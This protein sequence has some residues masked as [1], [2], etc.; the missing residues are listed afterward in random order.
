MRRKDDLV[1]GL[2]VGTTKVCA[3]VAEK[4]DNGDVRII[5]MGM[6]PSNGLRKG[7]VVNMESTIGSIGRAIEKAE[8]M[9]DV[10]INSVFAGIAG[11]HID[12]FNSRACIPIT[13]SSGEILESDIQKALSAARAT[14][15]PIDREVVH[16][17]PQGFLVD[18]HEVGK[19]PRGMSGMRL[20]AKVHIITGAIT[21]AQ[22]IILCI[23]RAGFAVED[24]VLEPLASALAVLTEE[25]K[26]SGVL[27][28]DIGG[29]TTDYVV[30]TGGAIR[31]SN[32]L[33]L[34]GDHLTND[35]A[36]VLKIPMS[37]AEEIKKEYASAGRENVGESDEIAVRC[38]VGQPNRII[39]RK[40]LCDIAH[41]RMDEIFSLIMREIH[42]SGYERRIS[43]G[44][45]LTGGASLLPGSVRMA[46]DIFDMPVR[47]GSPMG[48]SGLVEVLDNPIFATGVGLSKFGSH[49]R[50]SA[51]ESRFKGRHLF[52]RVLERMSDWFG[53][54]L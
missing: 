37:K 39:S 18:G 46:A 51:M 22:N 13:R 15:I 12:S 9:S 52:S 4:G 21:S 11:G 27:L 3:I 8:E 36:I 54:K 10:E 14:Y 30:F 38:G 33:S 20:E 23:N 32:V 6:S 31:H 28:I 40:E 42:K 29:G 35:I 47:M 44:V 48:V 41:S 5:G 1:I 34:G 50:S 49:W 16:A 19:D 24:I 26:E 43:S 7:V 45:V 2:D 25:E 17:I 53:E